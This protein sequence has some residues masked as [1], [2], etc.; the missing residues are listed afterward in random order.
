MWHAERLTFLAYTKSKE[1]SDGLFGHESIPSGTKYEYMLKLVSHVLFQEKSRWATQEHPSEIKRKLTSGI[2]V[3]EIGVRLFACV[4]CVQTT[5]K[6]YAYPLCY[7]PAIEGMLDVTFDT[8]LLTALLT[9]A[10]AGH[11]V[12]FFSAIGT[13]G[14]RGFFFVAKLRLWAAK[15]RSWSWRERKRV[16]F[17][18]SPGSRSRLRRSQSQLRYEKKTLWHPG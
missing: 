13:L 6:G 11:V 5:T 4:K 9:A 10:D 14:A 17:S 7:D 8:P 12:A 18:L 2:A 15:P 16:F 1:T 3:T